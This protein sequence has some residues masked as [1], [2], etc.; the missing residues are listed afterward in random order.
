MYHGVN[1]RGD[2]F[3]VSPSVFERQLRYLRAKVDIISLAQLLEHL[4]GKPLERDA[5]ALTFDDGYADFR[6]EAMPILERFKASATVF[7]L[8]GPVDRKE[9]GNDAPLLAP[10]ESA[11]LACELVTLGSHGLT[12]K[13][14]SRMPRAE[15][16]HELKGSR[17]ALASAGRALEFFAYPKGSYNEEAK[18][19]A[20]EA[21]YAAA[22]SAVATSVPKDVD[23]Y[24]IPRIQ[25]DRAT[26]ISE[27]KAKLTPAADWYYRLWK[28]F[29]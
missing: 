24:A 3:S 7:A 4:A 26:S 22:F 6:D 9:L 12:H 18:R 21:G 25:I 19:L 14:I 16:L 1:E 27:F 2:F 10:A 11:A 8:A 13:K 17:E 29:G 15:M 5:V 28:R 23:R 20:K